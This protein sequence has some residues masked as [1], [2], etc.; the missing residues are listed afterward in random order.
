M[1]RTRVG[2]AE[3][4]LTLKTGQF[5]AGIEKAKG[6]IAGLKGRFQDLRTEIN[7]TSGQLRAL[8]AIAGAGYAA[9]RIFEL[10]AAVEETGSKFSTVFGDEA[11]GVQAGIDQFATLAGLSKSAAQE[12]TATTGAIVRGFGVSAKAAAELSVSATKLAGDLASFNNVPVAETAV[13]IQAGLT[14]EMESLKRLGIAVLDADV[15]KR[16][17]VMTG[18]SLAAALTAE[19]IVM[20]RF[21]LITERAGVQVGDLERTSGTAAAQARQLNADL[22]NIAETIASALLPPMAFLVEKFRSLVQWIEFAGAKVAVLFEGFKVLIAILSRNDEAVATAVTNLNRMAAAA[23]EVADEIAGIGVAAGSGGSGG[24]GSGATGAIANLGKRTAN[25]ITTWTTAQGVAISLA[26]N[27]TAVGQA[28]GFAADEQTRLNSATSRF[29]ALSGA[30]GFLANN[31]GA[32]SF[33]AGPVGQIAGA[34]GVGKGL[35]DAFGGGSSAKS[36]SSGELTVRIVGM[37]DG[38]VQTV[39]GRIDQLHNLDVPVIV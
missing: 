13:A 12:V 38:A 33:L 6:N 7:T 5:T 9:K 31:V 18:K 36:V 11:G 30:V 2:S 25:L 3:I 4:D 32:L 26:T 15:K 37:S 20:A 22:T 29:N 17:L 10:G 28:A 27:L 1:A 8:G 35:S 19:E 34:V 14:G 39:R 23:E 16:A 21:A 24:V